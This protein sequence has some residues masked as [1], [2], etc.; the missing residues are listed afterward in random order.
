MPWVV[1]ECG[2]RGATG[3]GREGLLVVDWVTRSSFSSSLSR[4]SPLYRVE[5][6]N[7]QKGCHRPRR[8]VGGHV[9]WLGFSACAEKGL[10]LFNSYLFILLFLPVVLAGYFVLGRR[11]NLAPV[12][13][14]ALASLAFYAV[15]N[16]QFVLLLLASIAFNYGIGYLLIERKLRPALALCRAH[17]RRRRRSAGARH[18]QICRLLRRQSQCAVCD[19]L[20]RS[21]S[22]CRSAS[23]S[24]PSPR[25]RSW[26]M[27]IGARS[28]AMRC[29]ITRCS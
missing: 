6:A 11:S 5:S 17:G 23:P 19:P 3:A 10:M 7:C 18:L 27:P 9:V 21:T 8:V 12:V 22:C 4:R 14:L 13:W 24:T 29:R 16:W 28:R 2:R 26:S 1:K 15:S 20:C 25:S